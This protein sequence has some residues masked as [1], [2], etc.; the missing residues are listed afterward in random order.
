MDTTGSA[1]TNAITQTVMMTFT[2]RLKV[3]NIFTRRGKLKMRRD[4]CRMPASATCQMASQRSMEKHVIVRM[5]AI[6]Q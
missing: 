4:N 3:E 2:A 5:L 6:K 1:A